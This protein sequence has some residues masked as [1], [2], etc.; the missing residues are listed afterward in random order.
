VGQVAAD[1]DA[2]AIGVDVV[3]DRCKPVAEPPVDRLLRCPEGGDRLAAV[4][5]V[6]KLRVHHPA[7]QSA[8][9]VR[10]K[11]ADDGDAGARKRTAGDGQAKRECA[12][13]ADDFVAVEDGV[14]SVGWQQRTEALGVLAGRRPPEVVPDRRERRGL[15][16]EVSD[17][18][19]TERHAAIV[20]CRDRHHAIRGASAR[21]VRL[22]SD[23]GC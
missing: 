3:R 6:A 4:A 12:R 23:T 11:D 20:V 10:R 17:G 22:K 18:A 21:G 14:H 19:D 2:V 13:A 5:D 16:V 15:L 8:T 7:Q 9:A 1:C